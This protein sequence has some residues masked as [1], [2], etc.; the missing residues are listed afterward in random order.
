MPKIKKSIGEGH[1]TGELYTLL[2]GVKADLAAIR[3]AF[4]AHR[5]SVAGASGTGTA[6]SGDGAA[7]AGAVASTITLTVE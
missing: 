7:A 3:T 2:L 5:H 1:G 6:P 4:L